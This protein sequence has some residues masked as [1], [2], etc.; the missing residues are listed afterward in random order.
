MS[1]LPVGY[2]CYISETSANCAQVLQIVVGELVHN[3][4]ESA[5]SG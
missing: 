3:E 2:I 1:K 4:V 5:L